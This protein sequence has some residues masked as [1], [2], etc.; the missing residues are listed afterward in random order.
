MSELLV[1]LAEAVGLLLARLS[2]HVVDRSMVTVVRGGRAHAG[3]AVVADRVT[4]RAV[5]CV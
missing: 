4:D 5:A 3:S 2:E 1:A